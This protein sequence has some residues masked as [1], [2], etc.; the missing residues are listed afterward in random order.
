V[1]F[2]V[3]K[4]LQEQGARALVAEVGRRLRAVVYTSTRS[5][6]LLKPLDSIPAPGV[7]SDLTLEDLNASHLAGLS[8]LNRR[9]GRPG[10]DKRFAKAVASGFHGFVGYRGDQIVGY[11]WW[12]DRNA[13]VPHPDFRKLSLGIELEEGDVYGSDFFLLK[14]HRGGGT[15]SDFLFKLETSLRNRGY[16]RI[17]GYI[18]SGNRPA[19]WLYSTRD[20]KS[21]WAVSRRRLL[22]LRQTR[23]VPI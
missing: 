5:I 16:R 15:A 19:R 4:Y 3:R 18:E 21:M 13:P 23:K 20:Y 2:R 8:E 14:E 1:L 12:V 9:R 17:W 22:L 7:A 6:V 11:Y 10:V